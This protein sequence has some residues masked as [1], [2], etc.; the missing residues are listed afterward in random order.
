MQI[1]CAICKETEKVLP[2]K[3]TS[4]TFI[5]GKQTC[6]AIDQL[7]SCFMSRVDLTL[8][9]ETCAGIIIFCSLTFVFLSNVKKSDSL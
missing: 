9:C 7:V 1:V 6:S 3:K 2:C 8:N 5:H 4:E